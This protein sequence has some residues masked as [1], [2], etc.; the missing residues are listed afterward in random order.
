MRLELVPAAPLSEANFFRQA[1]EARHQVIKVMNYMALG[2]Y[3][4]PDEVWMPSILC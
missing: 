1:I 3:E 4:S 2:P